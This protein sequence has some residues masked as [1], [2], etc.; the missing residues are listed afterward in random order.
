M[1]INEIDDGYIALEYEG[2][3]LEDGSYQ[4][5]ILLLKLDTNLEIENKLDIDAEDAESFWD[6]VSN[7]EIKIE[8]IEDG[9]Y[10]MLNISTGE[11]SNYIEEVVVEAYPADAP[12]LTVSNELQKYEYK[13]EYYYDGEIDESLTETLEEKYGKTVES[14][15]D[16]V[17]ENYVLEKTENLP[18]TITNDQE[19]NVIKIYYAT[20]A[21]AT[22]QYIDKDTGEI[23]YEETEDGYEVVMN[24][25][26]YNKDDVK[27][28]LKDGYLIVSATTNINN[29]QKDENGKYIRRER[30]SGS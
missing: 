4:S 7:D 17:K 13:V 19:K 21:Q 14:Y 28:E 10:N 6:I 2:E 15:T 22:V 12:T 9:S 24:L 8:Q 25:P 20:K 5:R 23:I 16:K 26:G 27:G 3:N 29:D 1:Y 11:L 30:Y 18:L